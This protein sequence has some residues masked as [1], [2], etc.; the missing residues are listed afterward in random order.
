MAISV[1]KSICLYV[2]KSFI[3]CIDSAITAHNSEEYG[4]LEFIFLN[5][6]YIVLCILRVATSCFFQQTVLTVHS[7]MFYC[8]NFTTTTS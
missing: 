8:F 1:Y 2:L 7:D 5:E 6:L 3:C 4:M